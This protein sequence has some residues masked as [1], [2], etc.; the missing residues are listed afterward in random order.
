MAELLI[1]EKAKL[2]EVLTSIEELVAMFNELTDIAGYVRTPWVQEL[3]KT[4]QE[5]LTKYG[6]K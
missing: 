4:A 6:R 3:N 1:I 2:V 5:L